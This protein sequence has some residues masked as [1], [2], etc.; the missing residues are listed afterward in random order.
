MSTS[1]AW[2]PTLLL[3]V[4]IAATATILAGSVTTGPGHETVFKQIAKSVLGLDPGDISYVWGDTD[5][6]PFGHGSGGS[7]SSSLGGSAIHLAATRI[8]DKAKRIAA[9]ML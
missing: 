3:R 8:A 4:P 1:R 2:S 6:V 5:K 9:H 7:R